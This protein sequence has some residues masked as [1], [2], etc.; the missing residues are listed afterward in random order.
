MLASRRGPIVIAIDGG[1]GAGKST[2]S[3]LLA[4]KLGA[5]LIQSDDFFSA[6]IPDA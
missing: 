1:S 3:T 4:T 6:E 5:A 2:L